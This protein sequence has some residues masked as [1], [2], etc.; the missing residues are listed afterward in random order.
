MKKDVPNTFYTGNLSRAWVAKY[1][2]TLQAK[3][4][5]P[6]IQV[7]MNHIVESISLHGLFNHFNQEVFGKV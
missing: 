7:F 1:A 6:Y 2:A 3:D 4:V 5:I